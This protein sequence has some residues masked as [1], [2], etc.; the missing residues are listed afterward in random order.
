[1][2]SRCLLGQKLVRVIFLRG[3]VMWFS[4]LTSTCFFQVSH[5]RRLIYWNRSVSTVEKMDQ[6]TTLLS[7][8]LER[9]R[10]YSLCF[11]KMAWWKRESME[12]GHEA[13]ISCM[14]GTIKYLCLW[15]MYVSSVIRVPP[16]WIHLQSSWWLH[17]LHC[18]SWLSPCDYSL[19]SNPDAAFDVASLSV[20][21]KRGPPTEPRANPSRQQPLLDSYNSY[22]STL[23]FLSI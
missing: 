14:Y 23:Q 12:N 22:N 7:S 15:C 6:K 2:F 18:P 1:M 9:E 11:R 10:R 16:H 8:A 3:V 21:E 5:E 20:S 19:A 17:C 13:W 4:L